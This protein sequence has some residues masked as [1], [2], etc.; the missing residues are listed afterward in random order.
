[1]LYRKTTGASRTS[2]LRSS[3]AFMAFAAILVLGGCGQQGRL[4]T[5]PVRGT[6]TLDG[7]PLPY[8]QVLFMP[9]NGR[10]AKGEIVDGRFTLGTYS[11]SD[12]AVLGKH[13]VS[14]TARK[15]VETNL[16]DPL[17]VPQYN[18]SL[19]PERY[20]DPATS[21]LVFEVTADGNEFHIELSSKL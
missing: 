6:V 17:A 11:A 16:N 12:G 10:V 20:S 19:I 21:G 5:V 1:M 3:L 13:R 8:G 7:K 2:G 14:V 18:P 9:D 15:P 4:T